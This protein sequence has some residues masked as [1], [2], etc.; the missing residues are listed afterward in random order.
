MLENTPTYWIGYFP[1][2]VLIASGMTLTIPALTTLVFDASPDAD[3]GTASAINNAA[4]RTGGLLAVA[5]LGIAFGKADASSLSV[6]GVTAAYRSVMFCSA[7]AA[8]ASAACA[9]LISRAGK[10]TVDG[11]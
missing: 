5:A 7:V 2:L 4:A 10:T 6:E 11:L 3:S 1:G 9:V 8:L